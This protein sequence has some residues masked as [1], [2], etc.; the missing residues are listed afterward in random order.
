MAANGKGVQERAGEIGCL[1][2]IPAPLLAAKQRRMSNQRRG[3]CGDDALVIPG[4][5]SH[6]VK[7]G[8]SMTRNRM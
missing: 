2:R 5:K 7:G 1:E 4:Q 3:E 6:F 8:T